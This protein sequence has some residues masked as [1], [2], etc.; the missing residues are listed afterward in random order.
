LEALILDQCDGRYAIVDEGPG[1]SGSSF[2]AV[3]NWLVDH[4]IHEEQLIFFPSH[5]NEPG[6]QVSAA[7]IARWRRVRRH[8]VDFGTIQRDVI[9][10]LTKELA[11]PHQKTRWNEISAG[12]WR[13]RMFVTESQ[14]P[15]AHVQQERRK[16][17][18]ESGGT[19]CL[20]KFAG[21]GRYG[22]DALERGKR[23]SSAGFI[24]PVHSLR[25]GFLV[26]QW[27]ADARPLLDP[28]S[29]NRSDRIAL[30]ETVAQYLE[31]EADQLPATNAGASPKN[32]WE[33]A[34]FNISAHFGSEFEDALDEW[35]RAVEWIADSAQP[36]N[37]D[38]KMQPWEWLR[39]RDGSWLK[40]DALDHHADHQYI[41]PQDIAWDVAGAVCELELDDSEAAELKHRLGLHSRACHSSEAYIFYEVCYLAFQIG[42]CTLAASSLGHLP[43]EKNRFSCRRNFYAAQLHRLQTASANHA[44]RS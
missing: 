39:Q 19:T 41:G 29:L 22:R 7:N 10:E 26:Q 2:L 23:L 12:E 16:F 38:N 32:L 30:L 44:S 40:A 11:M 4:G 1:L 25:E 5:G 9:H 14:W 18:L 20:A 37:T 13:S 36:V 28:Q 24:P 21:L 34:R 17:L 6:S 43:D 42:Y 15:P 3:A 31:F 35:E 8:Y 33:M 27:L